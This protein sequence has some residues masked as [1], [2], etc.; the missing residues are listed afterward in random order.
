ML[1]STY[2]LSFIERNFY[3]INNLALS[4]HTVGLVILKNN[5]LLTKPLN[6]FCNTEI[7]VFG[8]YDFII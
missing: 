4:L 7:S 3:F 1:F 2:T 8:K 6:L 5:I